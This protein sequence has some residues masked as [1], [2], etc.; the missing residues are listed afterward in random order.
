[1]S[2]DNN[3]LLKIKVTNLDTNAEF[4]H[5]KVPISHVESFK[6]NPNLKVEVLGRSR[7]SSFRNSQ[8]SQN[9]RES[10]NSSGS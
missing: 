2:R 4:I 1:M 6:M 10:E 5:V 3:I 7:G 8:E 9:V